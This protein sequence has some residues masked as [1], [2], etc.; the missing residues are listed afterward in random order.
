MS[1]DTTDAVLFQRRGRTAIITINRPEVR[2]CVNGAVARGIEDAL[3]TLETDEE[4]WTGIITGAG[5]VFS[6]G[7]DLKAINA[8]RGSDIFTKRGG[9]AGIPSDSEISRSLQP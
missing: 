4:L 1:D 9:F 6:T 8:G 7:A 3:D 5:G 2:N